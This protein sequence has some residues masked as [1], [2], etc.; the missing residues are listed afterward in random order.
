ML[1]KCDG[2]KIFTPSQFAPKS[3]N[4]SQNT[5]HILMWFHLRFAFFFLFKS[6][7]EYILLFYRLQLQRLKSWRVRFFSRRNCKSFHWICSLGRMIEFQNRLG[8][9]IHRGIEIRQSL[10]MQWFGGILHHEGCPLFWWNVNWDWVID[11]TPELKW[12]DCK[13]I[14][15]INSMTENKRYLEVLIQTG[16]IIWNAHCFNFLSYKDCYVIG[17]EICT[18][19]RS[20]LGISCILWYCNWGWG[21]LG[22]GT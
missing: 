5:F 22:R 9:N 13:L 14:N 19:M 11:V 4:F 21:I 3:W 18:F 15:W 1:E 17:L 8:V 16:S 10:S 12:T 6:I 2:L 20:N 7:R